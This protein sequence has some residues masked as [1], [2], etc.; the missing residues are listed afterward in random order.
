MIYLHITLNISK[1]YLAKSG[2]HLPAVCE[3]WWNFA[4]HCMKLLGNVTV[5][6]TVLDWFLARSCLQLLLGHYSVQIG[7]Q[8]KHNYIK[9][10]LKHFFNNIFTFCTIGLLDKSRVATLAFLKPDFEILAFFEHLWIFLEIKKSLTK[11]G[12]FQSERLGSGKT[13]SELHI[14]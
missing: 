12:F 13:L 2:D 1:H 14:H 3:A 11:S 5:W 7:Y 10:V 4:P 9:I 6:P 8:R